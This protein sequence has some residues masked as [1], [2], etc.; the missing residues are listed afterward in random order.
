MTKY[1]GDEPRDKNGLTEAEFLA[2]YHAGDY[3][4]PSVAADMVIFTVMDTAKENYRKLTEK[5]LCLLLIQRGGHPFLGSWALPG[6]FIR[7]NETAMDAARRELKEETGL[8][9]VYLEQLYTFSEPDRDPRT[10]V[11]SCSHMA[12][13]DSTKL[14]LHAGDDADD[15]LWFEL[16]CRLLNEYTD[17]H[18]DKAVKSRR[19]LLEL[20]HGEIELSCVIEEKCIRSLYDSVR[21]YRI[22]ENHGLAFDHGKI[23]FYALERLRAQLETEDLALHL[24]PEEFTLTQLQQVYEVIWDR[25]LL[26]AAFR[27][28]VASLVT[29]TDSYTQ[30]EGHRPSRLYR[31]KSSADLAG[32][33]PHPPADAK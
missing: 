9:H 16:S 27:R 10:W 20:S 18:P 6:G 25:P 7:P 31:R 8:A 33:T 21:E 3:V 17:D 32:W 11:M 28:K 1:N 13:V 30:N 12:L 15:A 14:S 29:E 26:K 5:K 23:I 22:V 4:R 2:Q 24:M 19:I